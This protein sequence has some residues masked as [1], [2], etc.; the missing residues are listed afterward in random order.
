[1]SEPLANHLC[2]VDHKYAAEVMTRGMLMVQEFISRTRGHASGQPSTSTLPQT[3]TTPSGIPIMTYPPVPGYAMP[4]QPAWP[5]S[6]TPP[7]APTPTVLPPVAATTA[8]PSMVLQQPVVAASRT[9]RPG[10][11]TPL[12]TSQLLRDFL[13]SSSPSP[14]NTPRMPEDQC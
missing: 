8:I 5:F 9:P 4:G 7:V 3:T 13:R 2:A 11:S 6:Y 12:D 10:S 1:M 14:I